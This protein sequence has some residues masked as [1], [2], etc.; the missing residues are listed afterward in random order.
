MKGKWKKFEVRV[1]TNNDVFGLDTCAYLGEKDDPVNVKNLPYPASGLLEKPGTYK[2]QR[3]NRGGIEVGLVP[4][5]GNYHHHP[6]QY[7]NSHTLLCRH[8]CD[9]LDYDAQ[10]PETIRVKITKVK[11]QS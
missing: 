9:L 10:K 4:F 2:V 7:G 11:K 5:F 8:L 1:V 6:A 3:V